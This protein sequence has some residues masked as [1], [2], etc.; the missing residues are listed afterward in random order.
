MSL[1]G[2]EYHIIT[3]AIS[4]KIEDSKVKIFL[5]FSNQF[6]VDWELSID[7]MSY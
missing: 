7:I 1:A 3:S 4:I 5:N 6:R 2:M